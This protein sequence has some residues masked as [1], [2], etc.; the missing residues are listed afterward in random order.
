MRYQ[1]IGYYGVIGD[2]HTIALVGMNGSIDFMCFPDLD[3]PSIFARLLD[4]DHG[5]FFLLAPELEN[6]RKKQIYLSDTNILFSRFLS[7]EGVSEVSDFMPVETIS[8]QH[9]LV[10]RIKSVRGEIACQMIC[11]PA[12]DYGRSGHRIEAGNGEVLF[13]PEDDSITGLRL[14]TELPVDINDGAAVA[15][16]QLRPGESAAFVLEEAVPSGESLSSAPN[17]VSDAFKQTVNFWHR[18]VGQTQ[19]QGRWREQVNRSALTLKMLTSQKYGSIAA[20]GTFG[21]PEE[22]GGERNWDYRYTWIRDASF[23]LYGLIRLGYTTEAGNFMNW[24]E[25]RCNEPNPDGSLQTMYGMDGRHKLMETVLDHFEGYRKSIPIRIGNAAYDQLQLDIYGELM[26][27][28]YLYNKYGEPIS[29]ELWQNLV[30]LLDWLCEN[31]NQPDEGI[32]EVRGGKQEFLFSRLMC[33]VAIDRGIRLAMKRSFPAPIEHWHK[34]RD[35]I[36]NDIHTHFWNPEMG[37]F[38]QHPGTNAIDASSLLMP[39][40][41]FISPTDPRWLSHLKAVEDHLVYDSLVYRY[42]RETAA[43]DG[44]IGDEG[45]FSMCTFWYVECLARAGDLEKAR[46]YF[47]KMLGYANHLGLYAE[48]LSPRGE[49]LGNFPQAFTHLALISAAFELDR[50]LNQAGR[51]G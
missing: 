43:H 42:D 14:R 9:N 17:F 28:V 4:H 3:S 29:Y 11:K 33:W 40:V 22:I 38:M 24:L 20:A 35:E 12:F 10:R 30:R 39:L 25:Q 47:E 50:R 49:H 27:S 23:T 21:L 46:F 51:S 7:E 45:T 5:G 37:A 19:Y 6:A 2:L 8:P 26:D 16:F 32:W 34:V 36:Y 44:L 31:W 48:E 18:W 13:I 41:K 1:P 15:H